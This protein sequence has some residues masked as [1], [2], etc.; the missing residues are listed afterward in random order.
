M[1]RT[2]GLYIAWLI[3][4]G[5][6]VYADV[7]RHPYSF[8]TLLRWICCPVFGYSAFTAYEKNRVLW[9]WVFGVLA[10]LYNPIFRVHLDR[11]TWIGVNWFTA[12][13]LVVAAII[14]W[15]PSP[16]SPQLLVRHM[17]RSTMTI[18]EADRILDVVSAALQDESHSH[19]HAV[20]ALQGYDIFDIVTALKLR[21][22][23][24]F[25]LLSG[26][27]DFDAQFSDGLRL[28]DSIPWQIMNS[29]FADD[30][31]GQIGAKR[32][33]SMVDPATMQLDKRFVSVETGSSFGDFCKSLGA[34]APN[35]WQ[36]VYDRIGIKHTSD[37]PR[38]NAP[39]ILNT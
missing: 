21:I 35:Y 17:A 1:K 26:R 11:S 14:F 38:G 34:T 39:I 37:S 27:S 3:V 7:E 9:V 2:V 32:A 18:Q 29:F 23:N 31:V 19:G 5:L 15:R 12:A 33:M 10:A 20:S 13:V 28:Y 30:Q 25:L 4:A 22:A 6:L 36:R 8:Y 16:K 24:E